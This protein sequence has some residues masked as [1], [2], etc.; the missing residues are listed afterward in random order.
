MT[1]QCGE[2]VVNTPVYYVFSRILQLLNDSKF[3]LSVT[4]DIARS[5]PPL[6]TAIRIDVGVHAYKCYITLCRYTCRVCVYICTCTCMIC[7]TVGVWCRIANGVLEKISPQLLARN[8][9]TVSVWV[10]EASGVL[11]KVGQDALLKLFK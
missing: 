4:N 8:R 3:C 10:S 11:E 6:P 7:A 2:S 5:V 1:T 9:E